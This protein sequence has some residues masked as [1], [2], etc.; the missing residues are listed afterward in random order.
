MMMTT[1]DNKLSSGIDKFDHLEKEISEERKISFGLSIIQRLSLDSSQHYLCVDFY[2]VG[3]GYIL[4]CNIANANDN[5]NLEQSQP[6]ISGKP[7]LD[8][9][10]TN[11]SQLL[12]YPINKKP[13][14][15][16]ESIEFDCPFQFNLMICIPIFRLILGFINLNKQKSLMILI[17]DASRKCLLL[18]KQE[19][20]NHVYSILYIH[21]TSM[22]FVGMR[23]K[24]QNK[25]CPFFLYQEIQVVWVVFYYL[26]LNLFNLLLNHY[27][28]LN[29]LD[30][31]F[32]R[33]NQ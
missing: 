21:E 9:S 23:E 8:S 33:W 30:Y 18:S 17:G 10:P 2:D 6:L 28:F 19:I 4:M 29:F 22:L 11:S 32:N 7:I 24:F 5:S 12:V 20:P 3:Q 16:I 1:D 14:K 31:H 27:S 15:A 25:T 13:L 26:I